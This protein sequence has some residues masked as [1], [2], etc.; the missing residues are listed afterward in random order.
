MGLILDSSVMIA[1]TCLRFDLNLATLNEAEFARV[2]GLRIL[3]SRKYLLD[4]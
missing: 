4:A 1:A 3:E 2:D